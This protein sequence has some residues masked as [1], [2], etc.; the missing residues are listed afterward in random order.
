MGYQEQLA[1]VDSQLADLVKER[2]KFEAAYQRDIYTLDEFE[3]KMR[4]IRG[5]VNVLEVSRAKIESK[6]AETH[7]IEDQKRVVL[8]AL[9]KVRAEVE[10]AKGEKRQP[11]ELPFELKRKILSLLIDVIWVNSE[12]RTFTIEGEIKGTFALGTDEDE[13][14]STPI[15]GVT[16]N[17]LVFISGRRWRRCATCPSR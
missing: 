7:S 2:E 8:I 6:L 15:S 17:S 10:Q 9:G 16:D 11:N 5:K 14:A 1:F 13:T 12:E 4:D 3:E